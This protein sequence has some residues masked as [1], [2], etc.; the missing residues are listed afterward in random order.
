MIETLQSVALF[1]G[2]A[3]F[4]WLIYCA[5]R[6]AWDAEQEYKARE[7]ERQAARHCAKTGTPLR[8]EER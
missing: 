1:G 8:P 6:N 4:L 3:L 2:F 7:T 5:I